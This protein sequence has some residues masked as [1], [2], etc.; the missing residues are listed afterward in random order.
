MSKWQA[1]GHILSWFCM[2]FVVCVWRVDA[3][4]TLGSILGDITDSTGGRVAGSRIKIMDIERNL[5]QEKEVDGSG[6]F[7]FPVVRV[8]RYNVT[9]TAPGFNTFVQKDVKVDIGQ[10]VRLDI[11]LVVGQL[12]QNIVVDAQA[13]LLESTTSSVG[14]VIGG[15]QI[16][17]LP[18]NG[19]DFTQLAVLSANVIRASTTGAS[20]G[21]QLSVDGGRT[22]KTDFI[23]DGAQNTETTYNGV[24]LSP[25][26]D[27]IQEFK[28]ESNSFSAEYG[29]S[30]AVVNVAI[31]SG[32]NSFHGTAY[33]FLRNDKLDARN[34]FALSRPPLRQNQFGGSLGGP[35]VKNKLFFFGDYEAIRIRRGQTFNGRAATSAER[36]GNFSGSGVSVCNPSSIRPNTNGTGTVCD[37][38]P[39]NRIPEGMISPVAK[40]FLPFIPTPN[41]SSDRFIYNPS[42]KSDTNRGDARVDYNLRDNN[43]LF[44]RYSFQHLDN[45]APGATPLTGASA[46]ATFSQNA[47]LSDT[48]TFSPTWFNEAR[49][50]FSRLKLDSA[51]QGL[52]TNYTVESGILGFEETSRT[53]P[54][55]PNLAINN[56]L[57]VIGNSFNPIIATINGWQI[58]DH[59]TWVHG[60]QTT[61]FGFDMY[62]TA[63]PTLNNAFDRGSFDFNGG[64]S[65][66][67][68]ADYLMGYP[69]S[70][71]R[72][73]PRNLFGIRSANYG[74]FVQED[75]RVTSRLTIN[76][77]LRWDLMP[78]QSWIRSVAASYDYYGLT[79]LPGT[80]AL[81]ND[82]AGNIDLTSQ[83]VTRYNYPF[84]QD[85]VVS[86][87]EAGIPDNL[88]HT[89]WTNLAPRFGFAWR[90]FGEKTVIR[91]GF[92]T[93]FTLTQGLRSIGSGPINAPLQVDENL[94]VSNQVVPTRTIADL[95]PPFGQSFVQVGF[96]DIDPHQPTPYTF[97][98]NFGVQHQLTR[99]LLLEGVYTGNSSHKLEFTQPLNVPLP[100]PGPIAARRPVTRF[101]PGG[102]LANIGYGNMNSLRLRAEQRLD[103]D[104]T[105]LANYAWGKAIDSNTNEPTNG[106]VG[107]DPNNL[108]AERGRSNFD[109]RQRFVGSMIYG[110]PFG[111]GKRFLNQE[112]IVNI[113]A[114]G[115]RVGSIVTFQTGLP[116]TPNITGD[117]A[118]TGRPQRPNRFA[119]GEAAYRSTALWFDP[120]AFAVAAPFTYGNSGRNILDAPGL[121][122]WDLA[123][124]KD[125]QIREA[126]QIQFRAEFFNFTN[127]PFFGP[128]VTQINST[129]AGRINSAGEPRDIQFGLKFV[130]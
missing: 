93:F 100:G 106:G 85:I 12:T 19:R 122:N 115:W 92:G 68:F 126:Y 116:F 2:V 47:L 28:I 72:S 120:S 77:G 22:Q 32:T 70:A 56:Y 130:F 57:G 55:F 83:E 74:I 75:W 10:K 76:A 110:L 27:A 41:S 63:T 61:K 1:K 3:Q 44:S 66:D 103:H 60:K 117:P 23:L 89:N 99:S 121:R 35:I 16:V 111:R 109:I 18:L 14:Q 96:S 78:A 118:N 113:L 58:T 46:R 102:Y 124:Y 36:E 90:P 95:F 26:V 5:T 123:I 91:G 20:G 48:H 81:A 107:Q 30:S 108:A 69:S 45:Y 94:Q 105:F 52:G 65:G 25:S 6:S 87:R 15:K 21:S 114:G 59:L 40:F 24:R 42:N 97:Q 11:Q 104:L 128:P 17:D 127:T 129:Q 125:M 67:P 53:Y 43:I 88:V 80:L 82:S 84:V 51:P 38:F 112:G 71:S 37:P 62:R 50:S 33:E 54:G 73:F 31:K 8:G 49:L 34:F 9:V 39:E 4:V 7:I 13:A 79:K 64:F 101:G 119:S 86:A 29:R 98:W